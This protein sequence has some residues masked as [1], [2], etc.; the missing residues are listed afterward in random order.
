MR[1]V[2][3]EGSIDEGVGTQGKPINYAHRTTPIC[4][5]NAHLHHA[6]LNNSR[7]F[8]QPSHVHLHHQSAQQPSQ[9]IVR[10]SEAQG[11]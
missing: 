6:H 4:T 7:T 8:A 11:Q 3:T 1:V 2:L 9:L 10:T 5:T